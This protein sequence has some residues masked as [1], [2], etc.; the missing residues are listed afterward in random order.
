VDLAGEIFEPQG[1]ALT[2]LGDIDGK[3]LNL[4]I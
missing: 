4:K 3:N 2:V 1:I